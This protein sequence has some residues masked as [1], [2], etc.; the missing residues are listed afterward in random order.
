MP[1]PL[2]LVI[3]DDMG[4]NIKEGTQVL[5]AP[6]TDINHWV[7][8]ISRGTG[9]AGFMYPKA[10]VGVD[11]SNATINSSD[12]FITTPL[13]VKQFVAAALAALPT[14]DVKVQSIAYL[15]ALR[16]IRTIQTDGSTFDITIPQASNTV[17]G[18]LKIVQA[19]Q[20]S[21]AGSN[22]T[23]AATPALVSAMIAA[24]I[25]ALPAAFDTKVNGFVYNTATRQLVISDNNGS[26]FN[27]T[28][29]QAT[30]ALF[31]L[32][33]YATNA[34]YPA[35]NGSNT[36]SATPAFVMAAINDALSALPGD[37]FLQGLQSYDAMTNVM[38]LLMSDGSTVDVNL[39][40]LLNDAI[41]SIPHATA[42]VWG[43]TQLVVGNA[44]SASNTQAATPEWVNA[45]IAAAAH[46]PAAVNNTDGYIT[47]AAAGQVFTLTFNL[48]A[49]PSATAGARGLVVLAT[50]AEGP[51][52][53]DEVQATTPA[54]VESR[55]GTLV[56]AATGIVAGKVMLATSTE[57]AQPLNDSDA[58][59]PKY[60]ADVVAAAS[61]APMTFTSGDGSILNAGAGQ[62]LNLTVNPA[63][64]GGGSSPAFPMPWDVAVVDNNGT[65]SSSIRAGYQTI[66]A[67]VGPGPYSANPGLGGFVHI[68]GEQV[69]QTADG[70]HVWPMTATMAQ[71]RTPPLNGG[72]F[73]F[74]QGF[75]IFVDNDTATFTTELNFVGVLVRYNDG[76]DKT[77]MIG[78]NNFLGGFLPFTYGPTFTQSTLAS[79]RRPDMKVGTPSNS[80]GFPVNIFHIGMDIADVI[81][82]GATLISADLVAF[83]GTSTDSYGSCDQGWSAAGSWYARQPGSK[84]LAQFL[85]SAN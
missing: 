6:G 73:D 54:Y 14:T 43:V 15:P 51:A 85:A 72:V 1:I 75:F 78:P 3:P 46:A 10:A 67:G 13:F 28:L 25:A 38:T 39:T 64:L 26:T 34:M 23:D 49:V 74:S 61:H 62:A 19:S 65:G 9:Y 56:P 59:T 80:G 84:T 12:E 81:P 40:A 21:G 52:P 36:Y 76:A 45:A 44:A 27:V 70:W 37:K 29:P 58:A 11:A 77:V 79:M 20:I 33:K 82:A 53:A 24:A 4:S 16:V 35:Y 5:N 48:A 69:A 57:G 30:D 63:I 7:A 71:L 32:T 17:D 18:L 68:A 50:A 60:V 66:G 83:W 55:I 8:A 47:V 41:A 22:D 2:Y 42:T 31:G